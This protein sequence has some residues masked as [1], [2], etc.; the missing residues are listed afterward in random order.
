LEL[1]EN[2][3]FHHTRAIKEWL[4]A[5]SDR[6]TVFRQPL[7]SHGL[8]LIE[9]VWGHRK[10]TVRANVVFATFDDLTIAF[11]KGVLLEPKP[12]SDPAPRYLPVAGSLV[13][14]SRVEITCA[15]TR[16]PKSLG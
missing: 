15:Y 13:G 5:N 1:C 7:S 10:R 3:L 2:G 6:I 12:E 14:I 16:C 4:N 9:R 8:N 11:R